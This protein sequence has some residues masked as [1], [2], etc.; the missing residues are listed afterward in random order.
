MW[1][2]RTFGNKKKIHSSNRYW[3]VT[4]SGNSTVFSCRILLSKDIKITW[5][6]F[7]HEIVYLQRIIVGYNC[8]RAYVLLDCNS[9]GS[10]LQLV[11]FSYNPV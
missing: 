11:F 6:K 1:L 9:I 10:S 4:I 3:G 7:C 5:L 8:W 2:H